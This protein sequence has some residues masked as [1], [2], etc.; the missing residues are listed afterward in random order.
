[1]KEF[2]TDYDAAVGPIRMLGSEHGVQTSTW[3]CSAPIRW[4]R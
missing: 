4:R 3:C 2:G 1:M